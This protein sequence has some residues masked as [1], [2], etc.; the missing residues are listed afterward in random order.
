MKYA[1]FSDLCNNRM[2]ASKHKDKDYLQVMKK[3]PSPQLEIKQNM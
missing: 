3:S 1:G 2:T